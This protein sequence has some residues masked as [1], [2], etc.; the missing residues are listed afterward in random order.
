VLGFHRDFQ[1]VGPQNVLGIELN[2]YAAELAR[3]SIWIA[4]IQWCVRNGMGYARNPILRSLDGIECRD[5]VLNDDGSEA[6]WPEADYIVGNPPFLGDRKMIGELGEEYV[7]S[8]RHAYA[9]RVP[10]GADLVTY[11]F[12]KARAEIEAGRV[13]QA[14]LVS[15]NSIRGGA[16]RE[17]LKRICDSGRIF[18]A[19]SD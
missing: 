6:S 11:W 5:A 19:W 18:N 10:G 14:G 12:E 7:I 15:T 4:D 9:G 16:N 2:D 8:L 3:V 1:A 17:V 13:H